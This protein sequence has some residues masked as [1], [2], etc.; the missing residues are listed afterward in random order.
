MNNPY[1][2]IFV[3]GDC[4]NCLVVGGGK[5][6]ERKVE[7]LMESG[8]SVSVV[9]PQVTDGLAKLARQNR[10]RLIPER[11]EGRHLERVQLVIGATDDRAVNERI[12]LDAKQKGILVNIVDDPEYCSFIVP[13]VMTKGPLCVAVSTG[14]AAPKLAAK[15]RRELEA[16]IPDEYAAM[17]DELRILRPAIK[18]L[19]PDRKEQFWQAVSSLEVN[20]YQGKA[21]ALRQHLRKELDHFSRAAKQ[22]IAETRG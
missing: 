18:Q 13:S 20:S 10:I 17:I 6:A 21:D 4:L 2:P 8:A 16:F 5:V 9:S 1:Y 7:T 12:F 14:G 19:A 11:Y 3:K 22:R 15:I